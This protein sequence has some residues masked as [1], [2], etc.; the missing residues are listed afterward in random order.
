MTETRTYWVKCHWCDGSGDN[1][2][3]TCAKCFGE[4]VLQCEYEQ[5]VIEG[6]AGPAGPT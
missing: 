1:Q 4:G 6:E 2:S 5:L 3:W